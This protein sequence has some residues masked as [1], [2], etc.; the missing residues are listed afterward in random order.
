M[1]GNRLISIVALVTVCPAMV[2]LAWG[3]I[4]VHPYRLTRP[5]DEHPGKWSVPFQDITLQTADGL[6]LSAWYTPTENKIVILVGHGYANTRSAEMHVLF[7]RHGYGVLS[8]DFRAHGESEGE[9]CTLGYHEALD[10][11]AA[12]DFA[13]AQ[14]EVDRV[15]IWGGS[16][17]GI[18]ALRAA[19][20]RPEIEAIAIDSVPTSVADTVQITVRPAFL[21]QFVCHAAKWGTGLDPESLRPVDEIGRLNPRPLFIIQGTADQLIPV[22]S[23]QRLYD[24]AGEPRTLWIEPGVRHLEMYQDR[25]AEYERRVIQFFDRMIAVNGSL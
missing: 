4:G 3:W 7:S 22:D 10:V 5:A 20:R 2:G 25:P 19:V 15:G 18:A 17:G 9:T 11:E 24:A 8:W 12:L 13:L 16:M 6:R 1:R 14:P 21:R 23:A